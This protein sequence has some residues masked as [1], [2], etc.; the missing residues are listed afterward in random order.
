MATQQHYDAEVRV[1]KGRCAIATR[2][3]ATGTRVLLT[4]AFA[5][6]SVSSCNW[7][8]QSSAPAPAPQKPL[9]RCGG[10]K[11]L[12]YCSR[13]CQQLDWQRGA[14]ASECD[15]FKQIPDSVRGEAMQTVLLVTR[16]AAKLYM[17]NP[18]GSDEQQ[19]QLGDEVLQLRHHYR[20][21]ARIIPLI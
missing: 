10:C 3:I 17:Q 8:L 1:G 16:L 6:V 15:A 21:N 12:K 7:C 11:R 20:T 14:H 9:R 19:R 4:D 5:W 13:A 2:R 18:G